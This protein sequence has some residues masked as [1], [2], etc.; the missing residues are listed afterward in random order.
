MQGWVAGEENDGL[1]IQAPAS[2]PASISYYSPNG[3]RRVEQLPTVTV[4]AARGA[5]G[6][7]V[8]LRALWPMA[9]F[10]IP[11]MLDER[12]ALGEGDEPWYSPKVPAGRG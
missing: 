4:A 6:F 5:E 7:L 9:T 11:G 10:A 1:I 12:A 8:M 2:G 3:L